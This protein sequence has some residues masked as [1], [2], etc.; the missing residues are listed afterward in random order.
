MTAPVSRPLHVALAVAPHEMQATAAGVQHAFALIQQVCPGAYTLALSLHN[1]PADLLALP[2]LDCGLLSGAGEPADVGINDIECIWAE[3]VQ[4]LAA[5]GAVTMMLNQFRCVN[6]QEHDHL[7][8]LFRIRELNRTQITLARKNDLIIIDLDCVMA[9]LG[10]I[11]LG[12][13][14]RL[15]SL[16][17]HV[18]VV[19]TVAQALLSIGL[20]D[21]VDARSLDQA[22][23]MLSGLD[24]LRAAIIQLSRPRG[25]DAH[26]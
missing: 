20:R 15:T 2:S 13:D 4:A 8:R 7:E 6:R 18:A 24:E 22:L 14:H 12:C 5:R 23:K 1:S 3:R 25:S 9:D 11:F 10:G 21:K 16:G 19:Y 17:G 26:G